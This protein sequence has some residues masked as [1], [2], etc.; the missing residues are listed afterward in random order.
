MIFT[1]GRYVCI[2]VYIRIFKKLYIYL[3]LK[4][5][6]LL[7]YSYRHLSMNDNTIN[8]SIFCNK[9]K[10]SC[11]S[12]RWWRAHKRRITVFLEDSIWKYN[13]SLHNGGDLLSFYWH[14]RRCVRY[15]R[16][17]N[18]A[19]SSFL[20]KVPRQRHAAYPFVGVNILDGWSGEPEASLSPR[21]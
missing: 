19:C 18:S 8:Y 3:N 6:H 1:I 7:S 20:P 9:K 5:T 21:G 13:K 11:V 17:C 4:V 16:A 10:Y 12:G 2:C 14:C 15:S